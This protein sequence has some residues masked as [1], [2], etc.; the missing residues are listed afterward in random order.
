MLLSCPYCMRFRRWVNSIIG[1][2]PD[3]FREF[4]ELPLARGFG[5]ENHATTEFQVD[6]EGPLVG[7]ALKRPPL[8]LQRQTAPTLQ[9]SRTV[10]VLACITHLKPGAILVRVYRMAAI[11]HEGRERS[12]KVPC[13]MWQ[14]WHVPARTEYRLPVSAKPLAGVLALQPPVW[15]LDNTR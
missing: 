7:R 9:A 10:P 14:C 5:V 4:R 1:V 12:S 13:L 6:S 3:I 11:G 2:F 15:H 8:R